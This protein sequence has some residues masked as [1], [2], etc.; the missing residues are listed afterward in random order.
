MKQLEYT[1]FT[2]GGHGYH[3]QQT[4]ESS[5]RECTIQAGA[6]V[7]T[8]DTALTRVAGAIHTNV[9]TLTAARLKVATYIDTNQRIAGT[10]VRVP[11]ITTGIDTVA[12]V[13]VMAITNTVSLAHDHT[14]S[15]MI[16]QDCMI[17]HD[18]T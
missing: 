2:K 9:A 7:G 3:Y 16:P 11:L 14:R 5:Y 18:C 15:H 17:A 6:T 8:G 10:T 12:M 4:P 1:A 13:V